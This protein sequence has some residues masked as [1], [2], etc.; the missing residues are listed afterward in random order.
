[1]ARSWVRNTVEPTEFTIALEQPT[2]AGLEAACREDGHDSLLLLENRFT[3]GTG[4][5]EVRKLR[6]SG[7]RAPAV[8]MSAIPQRGLNE[9]ARAAGAQGTILKTGSGAALLAA[10]R[11]VAAGNDSFDGRHPPLPVGQGFL[12]PREREILRL[13]AR[14]ATNGEVAAQLGLGRESVKTLLSRAFQKL[15]AK[16]RTEAVSKAYEQGVL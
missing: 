4:L 16:G 13:V 14:G 10:L 3:R 1:M 6:S 9:A 11:T 8:L 15:G 5:D 2:L 12:S 7:F